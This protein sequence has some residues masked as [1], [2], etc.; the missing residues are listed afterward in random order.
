[1]KNYNWWLSRE[2][3]NNNNV[4]EGGFLGLDNISVFDRSHALPEGGR[5]DRQTVLHGWHCLV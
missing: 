3:A 1:M 4:F 2:D 5:L